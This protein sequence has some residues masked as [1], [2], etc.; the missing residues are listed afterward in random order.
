MDTLPEYINLFVNVTFHDHA[1]DPDE[2][3]TCRP[4]QLNIP[5]N[6]IATITWVP[7]D[8]NF[9]FEGFQWCGSNGFPL[10]QPII[11]DQCV[12]SAVH[13]T[14]PTR[15]QGIYRYQLTVT[16]KKNGKNYPTPNC[17]GPGEQGNGQPKINN[18]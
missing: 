9:T 13:N 3:I 2:I 11:H 12:I 8:D 17:P 6:A 15:S 1:N 5:S 7:T 16:A 4:H 18:Q 10:Q 14:D